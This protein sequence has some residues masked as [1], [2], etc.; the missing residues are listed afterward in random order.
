MISQLVDGEWVTSTDEEHR[1][2][3]LAEA[4]AEGLDLCPRCFFGDRTD[5]GV[6][7][8]CARDAV[9]N[10]DPDYRAWSDA[11]AR[12][13]FGAWAPDSDR[14]YTYDDAQADEALVHRLQARFNRFER[15]AKTDPDGCAI[16]GVPWRDHGQRWHPHAGFEVW[17]EPSLALR[18]DRIVARRNVRIGRPAWAA[19]NLA[20]AA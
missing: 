17:A 15:Y 1:A 6:C 5:S 2:Q 13:D 7:R 16:C 8:G 14:P 4:A 20:G 11:Q 9:F 3:I 10:A 12:L 18:K 19:L